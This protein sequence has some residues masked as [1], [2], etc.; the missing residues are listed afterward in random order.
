VTIRKIGPNKYRL[1][2]KA[3]KNLGTS[4]TKSGAEKRERQVNFFK[5][6]N[7]TK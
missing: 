1:Y 3:G 6:L 2:S 5:H 7:K 4:S